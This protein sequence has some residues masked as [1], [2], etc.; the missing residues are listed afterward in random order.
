MSNDI[1]DLLSRIAQITEGNITPTSVKSGLNPQQKKADQLPAL[2]RPH[3]ISVLDAPTD[4]QHPMKGMAVGA[5]EET[6]SGQGMVAKAGMIGGLSEP[7]ARAAA[8]VWP[9]ASAGVAEAMADIEEDMVGKIKKDLTDYLQGLENR[10]KDDGKRDKETPALDKLAKK[11]KTDRALQAKAKDTVEKGRVE[12]DPTQQDLE[13]EPPPAPIVNP[14]LPEGL[15]VET[16]I[17]SDDCIM[18]I[19]GN[20]TD[21]YEV[22]RGGNKLRTRFP[23]LDHARMAIDL[24]R[25]RRKEQEIGN[26]YIEER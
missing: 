12:E 13:V 9:K 18:E 20:D 3:T 10:V 4:P 26:D 21:G 22:C 6:A 11:D 1:R 23:K 14:T 16:M 25:A 17:L 15:A 8:S 24:Y 2:F 7:I 5:N 19:H